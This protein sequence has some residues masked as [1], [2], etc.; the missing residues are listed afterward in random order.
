MQR[1]WI[2]RSEGAEFDLPVEPGVGD[3]PIRVF[4][5]RPDTAFGVTYAVLAPEHPL[6]EA[7]IGDAD[8]RAAVERLRRAEVATQSEVERTAE[9][10]RQARP[11]PA[12]ARPSTRSTGARSRSTSPTTC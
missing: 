4:T 2:G 3:L 6:V 12:G 1:N 7:L 9:D 10:R 5:T 8:E 11:A